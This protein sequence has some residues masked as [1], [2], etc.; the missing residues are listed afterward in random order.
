MSRHISSACIALSVLL[1]IVVAVAT[2]A[3]QQTIRA[4]TPSDYDVVIDSAPCVA[5]PTAQ[6]SKTYKLATDP[7]MCRGPPTIDLGEKISCTCTFDELTP[8][9]VLPATA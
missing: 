6:R 2:N 4:C 5:N 1:C 9:L 8:H 3:Q 7:S